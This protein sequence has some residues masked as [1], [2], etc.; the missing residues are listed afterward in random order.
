MP[1]P[2]GSSRRMPYP[3]EWLED[4]RILTWYIRPKDWD[5]SR[6]K[7]AKLLLG[8]GDA[9]S[10]GADTSVVL[11]T[12]IGNSEFVCCGHCKASVPNDPKAGPSS[13]KLV[14]LNLRLEDW[15]MMKNRTAFTELL[16]AKKAGNNESVRQVEVFDPAPFRNLLARMVLDGN[17]IG[18]FGIALDKANVSST[19][20]SV[21][22]GVD[23]VKSYLSNS[24]DPL[25]LQA[26]TVIEDM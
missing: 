19:E 21:A 23:C 3:N 9:D 7:T 1:D 10:E 6:S 24:D 11:F 25:V 5:D 16:E 17:I 2:K 4:G 14:K 8:L 22:T 15:D 12:R 13:K 26:M 18:A 20:R